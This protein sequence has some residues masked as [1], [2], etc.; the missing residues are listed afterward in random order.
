MSNGVFSSQME[1]D[2][3]LLNIIFFSVNVCIPNWPVAFNLLVILH[4]IG[5]TC[6][7]SAYQTVLLGRW[8]VSLLVLEPL[9]LLL[10]KPCR[11]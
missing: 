5:C 6:S 8:V 2:T 9:S 11:P 1:S 10:V 7:R 4:W 3:Q